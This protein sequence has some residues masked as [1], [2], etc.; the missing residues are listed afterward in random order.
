MRLKPTLLS[1]C[2]LCAIFN[3][4]F[5]ANPD[6]N[7][8]FDIKAILQEA[9]TLTKVHDLSF[10]PQSSTVAGTY[11]V[12][13][14]TDQINAASFTATGAPKT[15]AKISFIQGSVDLNCQSGEC[16]TTGTKTITVNNFTCD[17]TGPA[18][19][20]TFDDNGR[21]TNMYVG[22]TETIAANNNSGTY[23]GSQTVT[24]AYQ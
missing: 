16:L 17:A 3:S 5:A 13:P 23:S 1:T 19:V 8:N 18:C 20:Y 9:I 14:K 15:A 4:S 22:A 24:L 10:P 2:V 12:D 6:G 7:S 11:T 21:I